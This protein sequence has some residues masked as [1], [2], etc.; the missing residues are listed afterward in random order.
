MKS[1]LGLQ[2][3]SC[4][5]EGIMLA[6]RYSSF[7][8]KPIYRRPGFHGGSTV[9]PPLYNISPLQRYLFFTISVN[10][11]GSGKAVDSPWYI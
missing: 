9:N 2:H 11:G 8:P 4:F 5:L 3:P 6:G 7:H 10:Y 1:M